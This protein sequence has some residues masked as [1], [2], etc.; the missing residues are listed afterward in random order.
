MNSVFLH[1]FLSGAIMLGF[2]AI[3]LFFVGFWKRTSDRLFLL[4]ACSFFL[5]A[6]ERLVLVLVSP[7]YEFRSYIYLIR[8]TAFLTIILAIV[9][10]NRAGK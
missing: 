5:L 3:G 8:L 1:A 6:I 4:F 7:D 2:A 10:R 9:D